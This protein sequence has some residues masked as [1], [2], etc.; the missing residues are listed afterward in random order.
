MT[1]HLTQ[2]AATG[3]HTFDVLQS[4]RAE[5]GQRRFS[6]FYSFYF[7]LITL[8]TSSRWFPLKETVALI[9]S[10]RDEENRRWSFPLP[11][12]A[13]RSSFWGNHP[14]ILSLCAATCS[15]PVKHASFADRVICWRGELLVFC[16]CES[17]V[18]W[19]RN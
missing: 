8:F 1:R 19:I 16:L 7:S 5:E 2:L 13:L 10:D 3:D 6:V 12:S 11:R 17:V 15:P 14:G 9:V 18:Q 4:R